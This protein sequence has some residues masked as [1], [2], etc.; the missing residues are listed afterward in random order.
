MVFN[1]GL[2][3]WADPLRLFR[4]R[5]DDLRSA[6]GERRDRT[7]IWSDHADLQRHHGRPRRE[8]R[9]PRRRRGFRRRLDHQVRERHPVGLHGHERTGPVG[10]HEW[11]PDQ[12]HGHGAE[13]A[14]RIHQP[15]RRGDRHEH[16][17]HRRHGGVH[18]RC[19]LDPDR[20]EL[21]PGRIEPPSRWR[22]S[23]FKV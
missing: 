23:E 4:Q 5:H 3:F 11:L 8:S 18:G 12:P 10:G 1:G 14:R 21:C 9:D 19:G 15:E 2:D 7:Q 13:C 17:R 6:G 22:S 20:G 16:R